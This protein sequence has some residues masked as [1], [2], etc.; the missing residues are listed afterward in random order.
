MYV[1]RL[2]GDEYIVLGHN[3]GEA[4]LSKAVARFKENLAKTPYYCAIGSSFRVDK[5]EAVENLI[6]RAEEKMYQDK[7]EFYKNAKFERRKA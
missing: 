3:V 5:N 2:G 1:Y 6:K 7:E 4:E